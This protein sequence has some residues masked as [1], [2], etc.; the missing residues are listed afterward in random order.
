METKVGKT[1]VVL[2]GQRNGPWHLDLDNPLG[3]EQALGRDVL[4]AFMKCFV[5]SDRLS[6]LAHL[7]ILS[8]TH[9]DGDGSR[10]GVRD[11]RLINL[12]L[13]GTMHELGGAMQ[14]LEGA[15]IR[16]G[17]RTVAGLQEMVDIRRRWFGKAAVA[18]IRNQLA[19]HLGDDEVYKKGWESIRGRQSLSLYRAD[20]RTGGNGTFDG[21][22]NLVARGLDREPSEYSEVS[23]Q[24]AD[25]LFKVP[26][27][28][29]AVF[30]G[31]VTASGI[32]VDDERSE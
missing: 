3:I 14:K 4:V 17:R 24:V 31:V 18:D 20:G 8:S 13:I 12:L 28:L 16:S 5:G 22:W 32:S 21:A 10:S 15:L 11:S 6:S 1:A 27:A 23:E 19:H 9:G 29:I 25:D 2:R 7:Y 30:R 26:A